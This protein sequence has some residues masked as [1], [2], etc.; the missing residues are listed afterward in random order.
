M[1]TLSS[2]P[3]ITR[4]WR[5]RFRRDHAFILLSV[6]IIAAT[7]MMI[8]RLNDHGPVSSGMS[9]VQAFA[10]LA[11]D[12]LVQLVWTQIVGVC[13]LAPMMSAPLIARERESGTSEHLL[14]TPLS[15]LRLVLEKWTAGALFLLLILFALYPLDLVALL[16][17]NSSFSG[18]GG[19]VLLGLGCLAWGGALGVACSAH[20]RRAALALRSATGISVVWLAGS[21]VCASIAGEASFLGRGFGSVPAYLVWFGRTNPVLCALDLLQPSPFLAPKW[22]FCAA[23]LVAGTLLFLLMAVLGLRKPLPEL[24]IIAPKQGGRGGVSGVLARLEMPLIGRFAPANPVLGREA[25]GKF[26]LRQPP[27][28]VLISEIILAL[29]VGVL[30]LAIAREAW[31]N[32]SSR[33]TVFWGVT[34]TGF[35]VSVL[36]AS[37]QGGAALA[38]EREGG[39]WEALQLSLLTPAQIVRGKLAASLA[40]MILLSFPA[41]PLLLL[42]LQWNGS[43]SATR[44]GN[45]IVGVQPFQFIAAVVIWLSTLWLQT[46]VA[47]FFSL[48]AKKVGGAIGGATGAALVW[49]LGSLFLLVL[50]SPS[51]G[52]LGFLAVI[53]PLVTLAMATDPPI[54]FLGSATGW[55]F[56]I[57]AFVAGLL[58]LSSIENGVRRLMNGEQGNRISN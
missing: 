3:V 15:P 10:P 25:R 37:A 41:W 48:R 34:W 21:M 18:L 46:L 6:L 40:T 26:R 50:G 19:V 44:Y 33:A 9:G 29:G 23:F 11:Q 16:L 13:L 17:G 42:C 4:E 12:L 2:F 22:P 56:A 49:M 51:E 24:H 1:P 39:T 36:A 28:A 58:L 32:P 43:W 54:E 53:N 35:V 20:A 8:D 31:I 30:Y 14:L 38:R 52:A 5:S 55:P 7:W 27:L 45:G 57:F 47:L